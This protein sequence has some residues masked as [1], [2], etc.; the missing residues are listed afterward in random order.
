MKGRLQGRSWLGG[1]QVAIIDEAEYLN[2]ESANSLLKLLEE[3]RQKNVFFLLTENENKILPTIRSRS[4]WW[5]FANVSDAE[6]LYGLGES[7]VGE[8]MAKEASVRAWGRPGRAFDLA[9][10]PEKMKSVQEEEDRWKKIRISPI[11]ERFKLVEKLI[12]EKATKGKAELDAALEVWVM[13]ER[14]QMLSAENNLDQ[15]IMIIDSLAQLRIW[16]RNNINIKLAAENF[17]ISF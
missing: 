2:E 6:I 3:P 10:D 9:R 14:Q 17:L 4:Q 15:S 8:Q 1:Y 13:I 5:R 16:I 12:G 11:H 7:S